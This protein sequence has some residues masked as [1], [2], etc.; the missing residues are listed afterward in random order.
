MGLSNCRECQ[1]EISTKAPFCPG[2][3]A[4]SP[5]S[6]GADVNDGATTREGHALPV[7][8]PPVLSSGWMS[9]KRMTAIVL[10]LIGAILGVVVML[11]GFGQRVDSNV[12]VVDVEALLNGR[13]ERIP[14]VAFVGEVPKLDGAADVRK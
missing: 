9:K 4:P 6:P 8:T 13:N 12:K 1:R 2:C 11:H 14:G 5:T 3:G 10:G 7:A